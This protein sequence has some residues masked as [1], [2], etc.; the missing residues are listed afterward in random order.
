MPS[1][2]ADLTA[3]LD[4]PILDMQQ[5]IRPHYSSNFNVSGG[6]RSKRTAKAG[7]SSPIFRTPSSEKIINNFPR[8]GSLETEFGPS[9]AGSRPVPQTG[10]PSPAPLDGTR[11]PILGVA[12]KSFGRHHTPTGNASNAGAEGIDGLYVSFN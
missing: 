9:K 12:E 2:R 11:T 6:A 3:K 4:A 7:P 5:H 8:V 1:A 10:Y